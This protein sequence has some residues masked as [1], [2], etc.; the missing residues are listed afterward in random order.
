MFL[1]WLIY[2]GAPVA[3]FYM[4]KL[5]DEPINK[6]DIVSSTTVAL[7][8]F[9]VLGALPLFFFMDPYRFEIGIR[10][11]ALVL[12]VLFLSV[13]NIVFFL[14]GVVVFRKK[15][16][17]N[18]YNFNLQCFVGLTK[19]QVTALIA[20]FMFCCVVLFFY[21]YKIERVAILVALTEGA[22]SALKARS[23]MGSSFDGKYHW[24][25]LVIVDVACVIFYT[26]MAQWLNNK[27]AF[28]FFFMLATF[29]FCAFVAI[30]T[31]EKAPFVWL[32]VGAFMVYAVIRKD[33][34]VSF[35]LIALLTALVLVALTLFYIFFMG[36]STLYDAVWRIFSRAFSGSITPAYFYL[37]FFPE[38]H[39][40]LLGRTFPNP[41]G[42]LPFEPYLYTV[43][44]MNWKFPEMASQGIVSTAPTVF[45]GEAYVNFG[46]FGVPV[47]AFLMGIFL[48]TISYL[49][50]RLDFDPVTVGL[51]VWLILFFKDLSVTGF[52]GYIYSLYLIFIVGFVI[53]IKSLKGRDAMIK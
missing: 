22:E 12:Q 53:I 48:A 13:V 52:S 44:V 46:P 47:V 40:Y 50:S 11:K 29:L 30:M 4:L 3:T 2:L 36:S 7:Y 15:T 5:A 18:F 51:S 6:V 37:Q 26:T 45:W 25:K 32:L 23:D 49:K 31:T 8:L 38:E 28:Y 21:L 14:A 27:K 16:K 17:A 19:T 20:T 10:D 41:G 35:R 43:E 34:F 1:F 24:Y 33:G 9:S 39:D 42:L